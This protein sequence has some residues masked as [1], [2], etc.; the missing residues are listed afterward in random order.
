MWEILQMA[1]IQ[2]L[3]CYACLESSNLTQVFPKLPK[4]NETLVHWR[5]YLF[6][7]NFFAREREDDIYSALKQSEHSPIWSE[8]AH[9]AKD[10]SVHSAQRAMGKMNN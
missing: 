9:T 8:H 4:A 10:C 1:L 2:I 3:I 6:S 5:K 7:D